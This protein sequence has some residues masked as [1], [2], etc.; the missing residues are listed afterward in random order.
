MTAI[1]AGVGLGLTNT[2]NNI[3]GTKGS[4]KGSGLAFCLADANQ[5]AHSRFPRKLKEIPQD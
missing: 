3:L 4:T 1:V 5:P 2:S